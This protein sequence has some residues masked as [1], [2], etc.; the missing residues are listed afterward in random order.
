MTPTK[1]GTSVETRFIEYHMLS[2]GRRMNVCHVWKSV[3]LGQ[4]NQQHKTTKY[5]Y[6]KKYRLKNG[7]HDGIIT[8]VAYTY[9]DRKY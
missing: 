9:I 4:I 5:Q 8:D 2:L 7:L 6:I 1:K 3:T